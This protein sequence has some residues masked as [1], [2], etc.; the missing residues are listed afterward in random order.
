[1]FKETNM[2]TIVVGCCD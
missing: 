2:L 1:M